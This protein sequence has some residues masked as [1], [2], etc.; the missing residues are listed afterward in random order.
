LRGLLREFADRGGAVLLSSHLLPEVEAVAD[1][2]VVIGRGRVLASG[3][4]S[5]LLARTGGGD[6][7][8]LFLELTADD[9]R[10]EVAS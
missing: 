2:L 10:E 6:L 4:M 8:Q 1:R 7:E 9:A 5:E 3:A